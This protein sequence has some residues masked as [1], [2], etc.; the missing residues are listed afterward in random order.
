MPVHVGFVVHKV[1]VEQV[2]LQVLQFSPVHK[3]QP[4]PHTHS[5]MQHWTYIDLAIDNIH[6]YNFKKPKGT[7]RH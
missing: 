3:I 5:F 1:A 6:K 7:Q 4:I 2:S